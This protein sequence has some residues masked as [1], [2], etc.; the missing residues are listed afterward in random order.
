MKGTRRAV[1]SLVLLCG[2]LLWM[3]ACAT[4]GGPMARN[5]FGA[6]GGAKTATNGA[7]SEECSTELPALV[8]RL[9]RL[10]RERTRIHGKLSNAGFER[11]S[12][13]ALSDGTGATGLALEA[14][15]SA[16]T[17]EKM[18]ADR[19]PVYSGLSGEIDWVAANW[20]DPSLMR[21]TPAKIR[22]LAAMAGDE[23]RD[24][25]AETMALRPMLTDIAAARR[26]QAELKDCA[27]RTFSAGDDGAA[28]AAERGRPPV[29]R[30]S[31]I[32]CSP[33]ATPKVKC[34]ETVNVDGGNVAALLRPV[35]S[36]SMSRDELS[37]LG[38]DAS[39]WIAFA[40]SAAGVGDGP[41]RVYVDGMPMLTS[42]PAAM[43]GRITVNGDPF[44]SEYSDVGEMRI[45]IDLNPVERRWHAELSAPS[46]GTGGGS[47]LGSTGKPISRSTSMS[48]SGPVP[49]LP[50]TFS[51]Y[52]AQ[53]L[54]ARR[55][56]FVAPESGALALAVD[57]VRITSRGADLVMSTAFVTD[58]ASVRATFS[59]SRLQ[60]DHAGIGGTNGPTTG[61]CLD[62]RNRRL[63][64]SWR[65]AAGDRIHR[66]GVSFTQDRLGVVADSLAP[67]VMLT[68]QLAV[69]G[70]ELA[71]NARRSDA[72]AVKH[73][74]ETGAGKWT[75]GVE[76]RSEI[77]SDERMPNPHGR[78]QISTNDAR[79]ATWIVS[80]GRSAAAARTTSAA[81]FAE[82]LTVHTP[83]LTLRTGLRVDW[84]NRAGAFVS[85]R[86]VAA[87]RVAGFQ[88]TGGAGV[89][90]QAWSPDLFVLAAER[91]GTRGATFVVHDVP[92]D[93]IDGSDRVNP[94]TGESLRTV[95]GPGFAPRR[96]LVVRAGVQR[97]FGLL[98]TGVEH[99]W[100]RGASL[101]GGERD[102]D[103]TGLVDRV[104]SDRALRR[105]QTYARSSF[106]RGADSIAAYYRHVWSFDDSDGPFVPPARQGDV[107]GEW[108]PS[109]GV[110][111]H[112]AGVTAAARLPGQIRLWLT[113]EARR[114]T[115]YT[116][117]TGDDPEGL[118]VFT[119]RGGRPRH[120]GTLPPFRKVS[121]SVSRTVRIPRAAWLAFDVGVRADNVT[122]HLNVTGVGRVV[123]TPAFGLPIDA[124]AGR[125]IRFWA[126]LA[127]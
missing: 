71:A 58:R 41:E 86:V 32:T 125:S 9:A 2:S 78:L 44:S 13:E 49:R 91:D 63:Q 29:D 25:K 96:D 54:D 35:N 88:L 98:Q 79:T 92:I 94:V 61:Q 23:F 47:P 112:A 12:A 83:R 53:R 3:G 66:G 5:R 18:L 46:F 56:L 20:F 82:Q 14:L 95:L 50:L 89:F 16:D 84:Q 101:P 108:A 124:A 117:L 33:Q 68:E 106:G 110:A 26:R 70:D 87:A 90:V 80:N 36:S 62:S 8:A 52:A 40:R 105:H 31:T 100:T 118:A 107:D 59:D 126:S 30:A 60:A 11:T 127:R 109:I 24:L 57:D 76:G 120:G 123:G 39:A 7:T 51:L 74:V 28:A 48:V 93:G 104:N 72:W 113:V 27:R 43:I 77:V 121:L 42:L 99:T 116:V 122:N 115:A 64:A 55:P 45:D 38:P 73:V 81:L 103:S 111:R 119:D 75:A 15:R 102:R 34:Q 65:V 21:W 6:R 22:S 97:R 1:A 85:P 19:T 67:L 37:G 10:E 17:L 114:G 69:G 4:S